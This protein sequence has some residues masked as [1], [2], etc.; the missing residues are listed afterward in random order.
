MPSTGQVG[1]PAWLAHA[2]WYV[3]PYNP[4]LPDRNSRTCPS[5]PSF[6]D[7]YAPFLTDF[8]PFVLN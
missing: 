4:C 1:D 5:H 2:Q 7:A 6:A 3:N 8:K